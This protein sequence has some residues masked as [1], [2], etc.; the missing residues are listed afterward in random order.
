MKILSVFTFIFVLSDVFAQTPEP[1]GP[2]PEMTSFCA[3][4]CVVCDIDGFTGVND[5]TAP[6]QDFGPE[7]DGGFTTDDLPNCFC[8]TQY[9][10]MQYIAFI[11]GSTSLTIKVDVGSCVGGAGGLELGFFETDD[12][13]TFQRLTFCNTDVDSGESETFIT[14]DVDGDGIAEDPDP[15]TIGQHY[16][17]VIDGSGGANCSWT[18]TVLEGSTQ[19]TPLS[20]SGIISISED[21]C[22][23]APITVSTTG[24]VGASQ[25]YWTLNGDAISD[26]S[27]TTEIS[28]PEV[29]T[30]ELCVT[31]ANACDEAPPTCTTFDVRE[32]GTTLILEDLCEGE[33]IEANGNQYCDEGIFQEVITLPNGCDS[34]ID[35][36]LAILP[37]AIANLDVWICNI[38]TFFIGTTPY[39]ET[40]SYSE[41][42]LSFA[43]CD[44]LV[45]LELLAIECEI[46][47]TAN[48]IPVVC[49]G[50]A[51]GTL[52]FSVDQGTPPLNY[53]YTNIEDNSITGM[54]TTNILINNEI[55]NIPIGIYRIY[56]EDNFGNDAVVLQEISEPEPLT[57]DLIPSDFGGFNVSCFEDED[58]LDR[59]GTLSTMVTGGVPPY[60]YL[61]SDGQSTEIAIGLA[62]ENYTVT[63]TDN[64]G[65]PI[66]LDYTLTSPAPILPNVDFVN[67]NCDG[68]DTGMIEILNVDGG[69]PN[70]TYSLSGTNFS[71]NAVFTD[72]LEGSYSV[73]VQDQN[74]CLVLV[75]DEILAP[76][77]PII[78]FEE[79]LELCLGDSIMLEAD[80]NDI[81][82]KSI[83][84][85]EPEYL[86]C[87]TCL[88]PIASPV[89]TSTFKLTI[90]SETDCSTSE[91]I[92]VNLI[93]NRNFYAPNVFTPNEDGLNERFTIFGSKEVAQIANLSIYDRWGNLV[94]KKENLSP[95]DVQNGWDG[96]FNNQEVDAGHYVWYAEIEFLDAEVI[97]YSGSVT[98]LR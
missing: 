86:N 20:T 98:L 21:P 39:T 66:T 11:A 73:Y 35:I 37:Q 72:L 58:G 94:F 84:W 81:N 77:I 22:T 79:D 15:L 30:Y 19:V 63:V 74:G 50:T 18:F 31:A 97:S 61:W 9:N 76:Q 23:D 78:T 1:C 89:N 33:C 42:I 53:T 70:Y 85:V 52:I 48:E 25:F 29:G 68:F 83:S 40:G 27:Q 43:E 44:S 60:A 59:N 4:A 6:G 34:I 80:I 49:N 14:G 56:I 17:L 91:S 7:C 88:S 8:T 82:I 51:S 64:S 71:S 92:R 41:T 65:C 3:T 12:C 90:V 32:V 5:L 46:L 47:A 62:A 28:V 87:D 16:Y 45:N 2:N 13:E 67:P 54:G 24:E 36:E 69:V 75:R 38:D 55:P 57:I 96:R 10:N 93:K 95:D 26:L